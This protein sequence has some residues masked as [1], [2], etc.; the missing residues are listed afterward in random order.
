MEFFVNN[1]LITVLLPLWAVLTIISG[2][3][4]K[5]AENRKL[6]A[7]LTL[8]STFIGIVFALGVLKYIHSMNILKLLY[9]IERLMSS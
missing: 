2:V 7:L 3:F 1:I 8:F 6:T 5:Y 4:F 9:L